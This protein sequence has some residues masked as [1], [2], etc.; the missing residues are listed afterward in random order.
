MNTEM[1]R[2]LLDSFYLAQQA[3][4]TLPPLPEGLTPQYVHIIDAI[5]HIEKERGSVCVSDIADWFQIAA[6][7]ITR[8]IRSMESL[9][10]VRKVRD[11]QD[12]RIVHIELTDLG[13]EWYD[14]Y[15]DQYHT[16]LAGI[17][18][19]I[20]ESDAKMTEMTIRSV[21][22]RMKENPITL[23]KAVPRSERQD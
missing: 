12:R 21:V 1:T 11:D 20:S 2:S 15:L 5:M 6:P 22:K 13:R 23:S 18:S 10:A 7:G 3:F 17:L 8:A 16:K 14:I 19:D 4:N 9:G